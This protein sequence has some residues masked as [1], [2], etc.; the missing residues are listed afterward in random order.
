MR[1]IRCL[2]GA[3]A[4]IAA[5]A[6]LG[7][8]GCSP[9]VDPAARADIDRRV[10]A[11][12]TPGQNYG[13]P[14]GFAPMPFQTGQWTTHKLVDQDGRPSF[15]TYKIVGEDGGAFWLETVTETYGGRSVTKLLVAIP[16]RMDLGSVDIR[17]A[18][19]KDHKGNVTRFDGPTLAIVR[20]TYRSIVSTLVVSWQ[21]LPQENVAV[22]AGEFAGCFKTRTDA[23][24]G[25][26]HA[27]STAWSHAA[28]PLSGLVKSQRIDRPSTM[29]LV[30]FGLAGAQPEL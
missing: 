30:A 16:N 29:E 22:A 1:T 24:W 18:A 11:L 15:M 23:T 4:A 27:A 17:A 7:A 13:A 20:N 9:S 2:S 21:G 10:A 14:T 8:A 6:V 19:F 25:P 26:W 28:V 12:G 5:A 3:A